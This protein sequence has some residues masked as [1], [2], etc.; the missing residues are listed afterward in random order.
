VA[1]TWLPAL[2]GRF[3]VENKGLAARV[4]SSSTMYSVAGQPYQTNAT[5]R[6]AIDTG[7]MANPWIFRACEVI[8]H[9]EIRRRITLRRGDDPHT[10]PEVKMREDPSRVLYCLNRRSNPIETAKMLRYRMVV[11]WLLSPR[12][13]PLEVTRSRAGRLALLNILDPDL[14]SPIPSRTS[15]ISAFEVLLNGDAGA[16][17]DVLPPF[18]PENTDQTNSILWL[19]SPHPTLIARGMSAMQPAGLSVELDRYARLYNRDYMQSGGRPGG[20]LG[21]R[22]QVTPETVTALQDRF[23]RDAR[24]GE[25]TAIQADAMFYQDLSTAPRD[26]QWGEVMD[27]MKHE[28]AMTFGVPESLMGDASG[29]TF[30]N[31]DAEYAIFLEH[32]FAPLMELI[33]D[34]LDLLTGGYDDDLWLRHDLS[35]LWVLKRHRRAEEDR[36]AEELSRGVITYNEYREF[37]GLPEIDAPWARVHWIP[38]N[39]AAGY[40]TD[41]GDAEEAVKTPIL[42]AGG[43]GMGAAPPE[44]GADQS[45][46]QGGFDQGGFD[47]GGFDQGGGFGALL[48]AGGDQLA[49][50]PGAADGGDGAGM[51]DAGQD[52]FTLAHGRPVAGLE[53]KEGRARVLAPAARWQ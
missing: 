21:V 17:R 40:E 15:P 36:M 49:L 7:F 29:S 51:R 45:G 43:G 44:P 9:T 18:D 50:P 23:N 20:I 37:L 14:V 22:G 41:P 4:R 8:A 32:R 42:T 34:Q 19:R 12:G 1:Q 16:G 6:H 3:G 2:R 48:D 38:P 5:A 11:L 10:S 30:D 26:M 31:A 35:D 28:A 25:T 13:V 24:P 27:R 39:M 52:Q 33:D 53:G 46:D 47:Q